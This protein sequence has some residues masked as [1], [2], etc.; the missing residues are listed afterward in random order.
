[1]TAGVETPVT[2]PTRSGGGAPGEGV[3]PTDWFPKV[4]LVAA[5]AVAVWS[6]VA[7]LTLSMWHDEVYTIDQYVQ[8]GPATIFFGD[9]VPNNHMLFNLLT[10]ASAELIAPTET[11]WRFWSVV[12]G[13]A[14]IAVVAAAV[15]R[16]VSPTAAALAAVMLTVSPLH[17][18][19]VPQARGYGLI[20]L[21]AAGMLFA[22]HVA[23]RM[24]PRPGVAL[25][26]VSG[27]V[28]IATLPVMVLPFLGHI[29]A[30]CL[31]PN[32]RRRAITATAIVGAAS[33]LWYLGVLSDLVRNSS[34]QYGERLSWHGPI[35][36]ISL[37]TDPWFRPLGLAGESPELTAVAVVAVLV[38]AALVFF[39]DRDLLAHT[40]LPVL[41]TL[42]VLTLARFYVLDRFI[43]ALLIPISVLLAAAAGYALAWVARRWRSRVPHIVV[44]VASLLALLPFMSLV[45][46]TVAVPQENFKAAAAIVSG[47][48]NVLIT[49]ARPDGWRHYLGS[50]GEGIN[51]DE[52]ASRVCAAVEPTAY[53]EHPFMADPVDT[54]CLEERGAVRIVLPQQTRDEIRIWFLDGT[55]PRRR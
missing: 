40:A 25:M 24:S 51:P 11:V 43:S 52:V 2:H 1:M 44:L 22:A 39:R 14:T 35:T 26:A 20:A 6:R 33:L 10:W 46:K 19:I 37:V 36:G 13:L 47:F 41:V 9:Y 27:W 54:R 42:T 32:L 34:Q 8:G 5:F 31:R 4:A 50:R 30:L 21:A 49:T 23:T 55:P 38:A 29:A 53:I 48:E 3:T 28:G 12:P 15:W 7:P 18:L 45:A 17:N 16:W